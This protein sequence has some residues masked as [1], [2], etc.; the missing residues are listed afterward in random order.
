[1][2]NQHIRE[3]KQVQNQNA[4]MS[5]PHK[6]SNT[7]PKKGGSFMQLLKISLKDLA[8]KDHNHAP[9]SSNGSSLH[10]KIDSPKASIP[11]PLESLQEPSIA[12]SPNNIPIK[13]ISEDLIQS[14]S[15]SYPNINSL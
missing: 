5:K 8:K 3:I 15:P 2:T 6:D 9:M 10:K 14:S 13:P 7:S 4:T 12:S 1:M 11:T